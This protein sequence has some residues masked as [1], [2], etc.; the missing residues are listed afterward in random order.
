MYLFME[1]RVLFR[2]ERPVFTTY[3]GVM[4]NNR[5]R[6][7]G[8]NIPISVLRISF[9]LCDSDIYT[10]WA[11]MTISIIDFSRSKGNPG[12]IRWGVYPADIAGAPI[13][14]PP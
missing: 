2:S 9:V 12:N 6:I 14:L 4:M 11:V 13:D 7:M 1:K 5:H 3:K 8:M 10:E